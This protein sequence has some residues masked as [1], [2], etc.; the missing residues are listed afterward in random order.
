MLHEALA[1]TRTTFDDYDSILVHQVSVP[2]L[3][4]FVRST[5]V[6]EARIETTLP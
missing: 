2:F 6:P 3:R 5:G 4:A 1:A